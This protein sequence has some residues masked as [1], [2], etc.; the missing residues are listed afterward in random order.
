M[1]DLPVLP[2][3]LVVGILGGTG[4]QGLGLGRR[5][6]DA[7]I[8]VVLGSREASRA[9]AAAAGLAAEGLPVRG[10]GNADA[11]AAGAMVIVA[12]PYP[13]HRE[14]LQGLAEPLRGRI[15][16]DCV[17]PLGFDD[18]GP[19]AL[20]VAAGS[21]AAEAAGVL[22]GARVVAAF[23]HVSAVLLCDASLADV[24]TDVLVC[25]D[26]RAAADLVVALA[27]VVPGMRGVY[28]GRLRLAGAVEMLT[29]NLIAVNRR[30]RAHAGVRLTGLSEPVRRVQARE[31]QEVDGG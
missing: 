30:Y 4:P 29:A 9:A 26:D 19:H 5:F 1:T 27:G 8:P 31:R 23:H 24:D 28:A 7:G 18:R 21:A 16:I 20:D 3:D 11:A 6:A 22:P 2:S 14:L 15:V 10:A 17:N 25:S 12:V 13:G